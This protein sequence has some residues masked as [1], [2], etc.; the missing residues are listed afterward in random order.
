MGSCLLNLSSHYVFCSSE[1]LWRI[2]FWF[3]FL[4]LSWF[5]SFALLMCVCACVCVCVCVCV[6]MC[7]CVY[8]CG[9]LPGTNFHFAQLFS[10][11]VLIAHLGLTFCDTMDCNPPGSSVHGILQARILEWV[12]IPFSRGS[13][14]PRDWTQV[15]CNE[16]RFFTIWATRE[17]FAWCSVDVFLSFFPFDIV[18]PLRSNS[19]RARILMLFSLFLQ[20]RQDTTELSWGTVQKYQGSAVI[21]KCVKCLLNGLPLWL[22]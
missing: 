6:W 22:S 20:A 3:L 16:G 2:S 12:A 11:E 4:H 9:W 14:Q 15:S 5:L 13:S 17:A 7:L 1:H 18:F 21:S 8:L 10:L 19:L